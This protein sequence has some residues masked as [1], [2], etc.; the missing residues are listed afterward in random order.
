MHRD[1]TTV[2][3]STSSSSAQSLSVSELPYFSPVDCK[4]HVF[5][6][7]SHTLT[8]ILGKILTET[9]LSKSWHN[10]GNQKLAFLIK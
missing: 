10:L 4:R 9:F 6:S 2:S 5:S 1:Y 3:G 8:V 7:Y